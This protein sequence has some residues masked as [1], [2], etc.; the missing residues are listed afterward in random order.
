M[1]D[2]IDIDIKRSIHSSA[3]HPLIDTFLFNASLQGFRAI[4]AN[5]EEPS[6]FMKCLSDRLNQFGRTKHLDE[7]CNDVTED[8]GNMPPIK[9]Q[10]RGKTQTVHLLPEK[11]GRLTKFLYFVPPNQ[12]NERPRISGQPVE[13]QSIPSV[14]IENETY[15]YI[16]DEANNQVVDLMNRRRKIQYHWEFIPDRF[17]SIYEHR[18][19]ILVE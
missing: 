3:Y 4:R 7:I 5:S 1:F 12:P 15:P 10:Q 11:I 14:V 19:R 16:S 6:F 2:S 18:C 17:E 13:L 9:I 8:M